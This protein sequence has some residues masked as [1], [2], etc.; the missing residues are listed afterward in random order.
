MRANHWALFQSKND[1]DRGSDEQLELNDVVVDGH[2]LKRLDP[3]DN[4]G[5]DS[6]VETSNGLAFQSG[7]IPYLL[8]LKLG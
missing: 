6:Q 4:G 5:N 7:H 2:Q 1:A 8:N 3:I